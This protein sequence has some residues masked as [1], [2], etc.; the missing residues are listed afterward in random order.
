MANMEYVTANKLTL[1][2]DDQKRSSRK[3]ILIGGLLIFVGS[4]FVHVFLSLFILLFTLL[5][6]AQQNGDEVLRVGAVGEDDAVR[7]LSNLPDTFTIFNQVNIP[8]SK[9]RTGYNEADIIVVGPEAIFIIEV[10]H[11]NGSIIGSEGEREWQVN[12]VGRGGTPYSKTMRSPIAQVKQLVWLLSEDMKKKNTRAWI[13][14]VVLFS[15]NEANVTVSEPTSIP[16]LRNS[17]LIDYLVSY[18]AKSKNF[19]VNK[20][21]HSIAGLKELS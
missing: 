18:E 9:S 11:N 1:E 15:N 16:V 5:A 17:Q 3:K 2:A 6:W 20:V 10:K 19:D 13:Q 12:K 4:L 21:K 7:L 8:N 14:G